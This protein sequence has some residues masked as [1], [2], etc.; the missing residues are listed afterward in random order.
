MY[1]SSFHGF[2][3]VWMS[4]K[5]EREREIVRDRQTERRHTH[6]GVQGTHLGNSPKVQTVKDASTVASVRWTSNEM[7]V[8]NTRATN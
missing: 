8:R 5:R 3:F 2:V 4:V 6:T 1:L 7:R